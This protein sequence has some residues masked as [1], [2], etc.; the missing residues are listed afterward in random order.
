MYWAMREKKTKKHWIRWLTFSSS[1]GSFYTSSGHNFHTIFDGV[2]AETEKTKKEFRN[3][4][5]HKARV[6]SNTHFAIL[7]TDSIEGIN[8][9]SYV[10]ISYD[11]LHLKVH[12]FFNFVSF[13]DFL[14]ARGK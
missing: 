9:A 14:Q 6:Y 4:G 10:R 2:L 1:S 3:W 11:L 12:S 13:T 7:F 5:D 8:V